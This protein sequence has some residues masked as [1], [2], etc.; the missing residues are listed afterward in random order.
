MRSLRTTYAIGG[1]PTRRRSERVCYQAPGSYTVLGAL[2]YSPS[3]LTLCTTPITSRHASAV[4][5]RANA[6]AER[7]GRCRRELARELL[8]DQRDAA[9][10]FDVGPR[11][12]AARDDSRAHGPRSSPASAEFG[13]ARRLGASAPA[14]RSFDDDL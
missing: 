5:G 6:F 2:A 7:A 10:R 8:G 12:V 11:E 14:G 4:D 13:S 9:A 3:S 1:A